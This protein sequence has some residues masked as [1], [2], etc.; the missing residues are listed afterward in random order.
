MVEKK[1]RK[2]RRKKLTKKQ[3]EFLQKV[4]EN[5]P[6][7]KHGLDN[8]EEFER[9]I[10]LDGHNL[11]WN[12]LTYH[13]MNEDGQLHREDGPALLSIDD[14]EEDITG[15]KWA[16]QGTSFLFNEMD[17]FLEYARENGMNHESETFIILKYG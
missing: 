3:L 8:L 14:V 6:I 9:R 16:W 7:V 15:Q 10:R 5:L 1:L 13:Y 11:I 12:Q 4:G 2:Q 17:S